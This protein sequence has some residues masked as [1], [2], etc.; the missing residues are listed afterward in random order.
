MAG[1]ARDH[2]RAAEIGFVDVGHHFHH[3]AGGSLARGINHPIH[4]IGTGTRVAIGAIEAQVG[5][6]GSHGS[7]EIVHNQA[8]Q[9]A[10]GDVLEGFASNLCFHCGGLGGLRFGA[11]DHGGAHQSHS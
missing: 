5:R 3:A 4:R 8:F 1:E 2:L 7:Q 6:N 11:L 10:G 9:C